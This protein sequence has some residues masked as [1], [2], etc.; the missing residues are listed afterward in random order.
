MSCELGET[1]PKS[2]RA[3]KKGYVRVQ[4]EKGCW[5]SLPE[6]FCSPARVQA[7]ELQDYAGHRPKSRGQS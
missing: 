7:G 2:T 5:L 4:V 6:S 1:S 3:P